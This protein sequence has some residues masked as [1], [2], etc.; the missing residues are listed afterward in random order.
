[1]DAAIA[2]GDLEPTEP[3]AIVMHEDDILDEMEAQCGKLGPACAA[4]L[5]G[6]YNSTSLAAAINNLGAVVR[7][8][9]VGPE[10][11]AGLAARN[12]R[13]ERL[14]LSEDVLVA[15][16]LLKLPE[17]YGAARSRP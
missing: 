2:S 15:L 14:Q 13:F 16:I 4:Y 8:A 9:V 5:E 11:V 10:Q 12:K 1:M 7:E 17:K 3:A 6:I